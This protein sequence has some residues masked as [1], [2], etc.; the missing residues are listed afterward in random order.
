MQVAGAMVVAHRDGVLHRDINPAN[1]LLDNNDDPYVVDFGLALRVDG[2]RARKGETAGT[3]AYMAPEQTRG[4]AKFSWM[5]ELTSGDWGSCYTKCSPARCLSTDVIANSCSKRFVSAH[6]HPASLFLRYR[7]GRKR[8]VCACLE[9]NPAQRYA[10]AG[11]VA[12]ALRRESP[13]SRSGRSW[14]LAGVAGLLLFGLSATAPH[15]LP[16]PAIDTDGSPAVTGD[17]R[18][19]RLGCTASGSTG[20]ACWRAGCRHCVVVTESARTFS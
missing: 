9:K 14:L 16:A 20:Q 3:L 18:F 6:N 2:Q 17:S 11:D 7:D 12:D 4:E 5:A 15:W 13:S 19:G 10:T 8:F 1:I